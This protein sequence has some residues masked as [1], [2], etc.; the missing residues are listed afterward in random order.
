M[1]GQKSEE[2]FIFQ[3]LYIFTHDMKLQL[4]CDP[5]VKAKVM[6]WNLEMMID[7]TPNEMAHRYIRKKETKH[8]I[9]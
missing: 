5:S 6:E 4:C 7:S 1:K 2:F 9:P 8:T 3:W